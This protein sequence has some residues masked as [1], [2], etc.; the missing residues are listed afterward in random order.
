MRAFASATAAAAFGERT[1]TPR[2]VRATSGGAGRFP[3]SGDGDRSRAK[4]G[5][6]S[7]GVRRDRG[8]GRETDQQE[9]RSNGRTKTDFHGALRRRAYRKAADIEA[10][11]CR[12]LGAMS[13]LQAILLGAVQGLT[14]FVPVSSTAHLFL[15]QKWLGLENESASLSFDIV[16]HLG[17]ALALIA[18]YA[19]ELSRMLEETLRWAARRPA[20]NPSD[21]ALIAPLI[22]GSSAL[23]W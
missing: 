1:S 19:R 9:C 3:D 10:P 11:A 14:E 6:F 22:L 16:L 17:T 8:A 5:A 4:R 18:V 7:G 15:A 23:R 13:L 20:R 21:R 2:L 12:K